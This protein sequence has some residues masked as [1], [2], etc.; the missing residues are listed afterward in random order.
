MIST[1]IIIMRKWR[2]ILRTKTLIEKRKNS[3]RWSIISFKL[4]SNDTD[5]GKKRN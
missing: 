1:E 2:R 5:P 4:T 3:R